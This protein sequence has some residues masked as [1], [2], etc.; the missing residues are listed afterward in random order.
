M[1]ACMGMHIPII[2]RPSWRDRTS[3]EHTGAPGVC[4]CMRSILLPMQS[5]ARHPRAGIRGGAHQCLHPVSVTVVHPLRHDTCRKPSRRSWR[6]QPGAAQCCG[7][8]APA[9]LTSQPRLS[10]PHPTCRDQLTALNISFR[11]PVAT[12]G[13]VAELGPAAASASPVVGLRAD[14]DGLPIDEPAG[15][16][17]AS[18]HPGKMHACGHDTHVAMLLGGGRQGKAGMRCRLQHIRGR[19]APPSARWVPGL[20]WWRPRQQPSELIMLEGAAVTTAAA[21]CRHHPS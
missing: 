13:I 21:A 18:T 8:A 3:W 17:Y 11:H 20:H 1:P 12:H 10:S 6:S 19:L 15:L 2:T 16:P 14:M 7:R 4:P 9:H 5:P